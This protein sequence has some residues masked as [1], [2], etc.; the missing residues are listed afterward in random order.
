MPERQL[1]PLSDPLPRG[2]SSPRSKMMRGS[3]SIDLGPPSPLLD[4]LAFSTGSAGSES[5]IDS[6]IS[7]RSFR[8]PSFAVDGY[9]AWENIGDQF[10]SLDYRHMPGPPALHDVPELSIDSTSSS[11]SSSSRTASS[12]FSIR[13]DGSSLDTLWF[14]PNVADSLPHMFPAGRDPSPA[15][16]NSQPE[17]PRISQ[18]I[19][20]VLENAFAHDVNPPPK[21]CV[22]LASCLGIETKTLDAWQRTTTMQPKRKKVLKPDHLIAKWKHKV[23]K[24]AAGLGICDDGLIDFLATGLRLE[25]AVLRRAL[26]DANEEH[27]HPKIPKSTKPCL[28]HDAPMKDVLLEET[29]RES[30]R[31]AAARDP[32]TPKNQAVKNFLSDSECSVE[33]DKE[34]QDRTFDEEVTALATI[35]GA[36]YASLAPAI[37]ALACMSPDTPPDSLSS[38]GSLTAG[39]PTASWESPGGL[40]DTSGGSSSPSNPNSGSPPFNPPSSSPND[41][42]KRKSPRD[43]GNDDG[44]DGQL[45]DGDSGGDHPSKRIKPDGP[46]SKLRYDC[47]I[48]RMAMALGDGTES[49]PACAPGG[50]EFRHV[51]FVA[52]SQ[53]PSRDRCDETVLLSV[54]TIN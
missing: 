10:S 46:T 19:R 2:L 29:S 28:T 23:I 8:L 48:A 53:L 6:T 14:T 12:S 32:V 42:Q 40:S 37:A 43:D 47:P 25:S 33:S 30:P 5:S 24:R 13:C 20:S 50:L 45:G 21:D 3:S 49:T 9:Q 38:P 52:P 44:E 35:L 36:D 16:V 31:L 27:W 17:P 41:N 26:R 11:S 51:W 1:Y 22:F 54:L 39:S 34:V 4:T 7:R 15:V 18:N